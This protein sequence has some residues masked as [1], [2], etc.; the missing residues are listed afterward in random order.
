MHEQE[1]VSEVLNEYFLM[2][3]AKEMVGE[4]NEILE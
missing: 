1:D 2:G 3:F 4:L